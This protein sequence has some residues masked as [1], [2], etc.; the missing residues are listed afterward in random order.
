MGSGHFT[1]KTLGMRFYLFTALAL[2]LA[3]TTGSD[4]VA[5]T[6]IAGEPIIGALREHFYW[7]SV[8]FVGTLFLFAPFVC[9]ALTL[10]RAEAYVRRRTIFLI[11]GIA[12]LIL[13]YFYFEGYQGSQ[14]AML[15]GRWTAATLSIGLLPFFI[16]I[17]TVLGAIG[18]SALA[19]KIDPRANR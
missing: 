19:A 13:G 11:G 1:G 3:A 15:E 6:T 10:S 18:A 9:L 16:G 17:P 12:A 14:R 7:A 8:Q 5:R 4:L 2:F